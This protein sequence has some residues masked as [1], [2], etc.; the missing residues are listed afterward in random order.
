MPSG[1]HGKPQHGSELA[2]S[3]PLLSVFMVETGVTAYY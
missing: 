2:W 1:G 3:R